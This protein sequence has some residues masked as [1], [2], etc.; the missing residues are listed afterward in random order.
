LIQWKLKSGAKD[1]YFKETNLIESQW[2]TFNDV[3]L[4]VPGGASVVAEQ[5]W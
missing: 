2:P 4:T 1:I 3:A 5:L